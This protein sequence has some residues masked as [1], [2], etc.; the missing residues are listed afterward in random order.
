MRKSL[1]FTIIFVLVGGLVAPHVFA[2]T[3]NDTVLF[4][5]PDGF[6]TIELPNDGWFRADTK[7]H[8]FLAP[9]AES[10]IRITGYTLLEDLDLTDSDILNEIQQKNR[11]YCSKQV[12]DDI[13]YE[14]AGCYK[15]Q[16]IDTEITYTNEGRK[17]QMMD[18]TYIIDGKI[19]S[20]DARI[21][22]GKAY[23]E[24][25]SRTLIDGS[26]A[27]PE[28]LQQIKEIIKSIVLLQPL[29]F[30]GIPNQTQAMIMASDLGVTESDIINNNIDFLQFKNYKNYQSTENNF[31]IEYPADFVIEEGY[32]SAHGSEGHVRFIPKSDPQ[33]STTAISGLFYL[34]VLV[35]CSTF[36]DVMHALEK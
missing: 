19:H 14:W 22:D 10:M 5:D 12:Y 6:Y 29:S 11:W 24:I 31:S 35:I 17:L 27:D 34:S 33:S 21:F 4:T 8:L 23:F 16:K 7:D 20:I 26:K 1:I 32:E 28:T 30:D 3:D 2:E 9:N 13:I 18:M 25:T 15:F 36:Y